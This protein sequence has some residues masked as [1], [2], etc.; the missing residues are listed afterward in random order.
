MISV[1][2][3]FN[4][5][6]KSLL[7][8]KCNK[9]I[10]KCLT[11]KQDHNF[12]TAY[13]E[14]DIKDA[15]EIIYNGIKC[16]YCE[17]I[18][19]KTSYIQVEHYRPKKKENKKQPEHQGYYWLGYEWTNLIFA[20][21]KCNTAKGNQFP[22]SKDGKRVTSPPIKS[23]NLDFGKCKIDF[24]ALL[25]EKPL[26]LNPEIDRPEDHIVFLPSG[27]AWGITLRGE[28]TI[29]I[30]DLNRYPLIINGKDGRKDM[31]DKIYFKIK[32]HII[33][34][35]DE[36]IDEKALDYCIKDVIG[37]LWGLRLPIR[38]FSSLGYFMFSEFD[39]FIARRFNRKV[40]R[41][42]LAKLDE[43]KNEFGLT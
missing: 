25:N 16:A 32:N 3:D 17:G 6:P 34:Y 43:F 36:K 28:K 2:K 7:S 20:C 10:T 40:R 26:L 12:T 41:L 42:L 4:K 27:K 29:S 15:L 39:L 18:P 1:E 5:P 21:Q 11:E 8:E 14:K 23:N 31:I 35:I 37:Y 24:S 19:S 30:C 9:A 33:D 38:E 13:K 22:L